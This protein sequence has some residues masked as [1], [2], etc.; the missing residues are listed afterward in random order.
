MITR[1]QAVAA[2]PAVAG[3]RVV[4]TYDAG[5]YWMVSR[6]AAEAG[7][8]MDLPVYFVHK[9]T[10]DLRQALMPRDLE[11]LDLIDESSFEAA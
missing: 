1:A 7:L 10:G 11:M 2:V 5:D 8:D 4:G 3:V 9:D 6:T